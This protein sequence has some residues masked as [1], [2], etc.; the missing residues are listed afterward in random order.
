MKHLAF[1]AVLALAFLVTP[2]AAL[3]VEV[4]RGPYLQMQTES[5]VIVRWRTDVA[6]DSVVRYGLTPGS[7]GQA[8]QVG[9]PTTD[10]SVTL[11]GLATDQQYYYSVGDSIES[12]AGDASYHFRTAPAQ[13]AAADTRIWVLGDSGTADAN[14]AAVRNAYVSWAGGDSADLWLMLGDNAYNDG[15]DAEYQAAVF[16][17]YPVMLRQMPLW[18]TLGNHDGHTA[19]SG[20]QSGPYYD[21]FDLPANAE[22]GGLA[23]GTEAY[24]AFDY[25]NIHFICLD[26]YDS[27]RGIDGPMLTW[28]EADLASNTQ[29]WVIAFWHHPPYSK[30]SH[31]SDTEPQLIDMRQNALPLLEVWGVDLVMTGHSHSY[32]RSFLIDGHYGGSGTYSPVNH[33]VDGGDG[34]ESGDGVYEKPDGVAAQNAGAV[35]A[36]AGSSG[37]I[38]G[39]ALNHPAMF[40]SLNSL[41]SLVLDV[42]GN[43]LDAVFLNQAGAVLDSFTILKTPDNEPPL[44]DSAAAEDAS[45]VRVGF[46]EPVEAATA[47]DPANYAIAG[48]GITA[49]QLLDGNR[50]VRLTT[51]SMTDATTY[52]LAVSNLR[53]LAGNT[54]APGSSIEFDY[55]E[56]MEASFQDGIAP[57]P[58]YAGTQDTY[59][60]QATATTNYGTAGSL[61]VDGDEPSGSGTDMNALLR[62]DTSAIP[63]GATVLAA[64][65][66]LEVTNVSTGMYGCFGLKRAWNESQ[67][68]WNLAASGSAWGAPGAGAAGDRDPT[69]LCTINA[70]SLGSLTVPLNGTGV[71]RVQSWV[72]DPAGN[73]GLILSDSS[74]SDGADFLSSESAT[75]VARPRLNVIYRVDAPP[76]PPPYLDQYALA[77]VLTN[78]TSSGNYLDTHADDGVT[79]ALTER[80]SGG[81]KDQRY[82]Y[83]DHTWQFTVAPG[84]SVTL[85]A[86]AWFGGSADGDAFT[87]AWSP[88]N[89]TYTPLFA[90]TSTSPANV[91][92]AAI[93]ASGTIFV[94]VSDTNRQAGNRALD[95]VFVDQLF[96]RS[97]NGTPPPNQPPGADFSSNCSNLDCNFTD[98]SSDPDG[99]LVDWAWAFGDGGTSANQHPSHAYASPGTYSVSLTVTDDDGATGV[100]GKNVTVA[101]GSA[102]SLAADGYKVRGVHVVDLHWSGAAGGTVRILRDGGPLTATANDGA[103]SDDTGNKGGRTYLYQV[104]EPLPSPNCSN[105]VT[106]VF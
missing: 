25:A 88:D 29:P 21:I 10:H 31:N 77:D 104:C 47:E 40:I 8:V 51:G 16:D 30:G 92:S 85:L 11:A 83:L 39:G 26:S 103:Y 20:T 55:F 82:S 54:I 66:V 14:A 106:I 99:T 22:I 4:I 89:G 76:P 74:T 46:N 58:S 34:R 78:G 62:W 67:A 18:A 28:L 7:L 65:L 17:I 98:T 63:P 87:F 35:Y 95:T 96:I 84:S 50:V 73:H 68:T 61:Q 56:T 97:A 91:Q 105:E 15:T 102:I 33:A 9:G 1:W 90:V 5:G 69:S 37:K 79:Q 24:Y 72:D 94:R 27:N 32:E 43:R 2:A 42:A 49:A 41:G 23:S 75:A 52:T 6:T 48:L 19:D 45:H 93:A 59:I 86:N 60:R 80:E 36:V 13:G 100:V 38:S 64:E 101:A 81:K 12:L 71:A 70:A 3:A 53:D 44:L 57:D